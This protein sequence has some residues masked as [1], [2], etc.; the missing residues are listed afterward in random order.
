[1]SK[2]IT[3]TY[4][5]NGQ[6]IDVLFT[7]TAFFNATVAAKAFGKKINDWLR[8]ESTAEYITAL[9]ASHQCYVAGNPVSEQNQLVR[10]VHGGDPA[11]Q[12]TW[13]HAKLAVPYAR[14]LNAN[15]AVWCDEIIFNLLRGGEPS[16]ASRPSFSADEQ[17]ATKLECTL[18]VANLLAVPVH[19]AQQEAVKEVRKE[20]GIDYTHLLVH[21]AAQ[22]TV[23]PDEVM[24]EPTQLSSALKFPSPIAVN[25]W[26]ASL[27]LQNKLKKGWEPTD[28]G[29]KYCS[30]HAWNAKN[31]SGYNLRWNHVKL[32]SLRENS[33][34]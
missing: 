22:Q 15:F 2:L 34:D 12:G 28:E 29:K 25:K 20:T 18:R 6:S 17:A 24:L 11:N 9:I 1:M 21:A 13:L 27:G 3:K 19:I 10:I 30:I 4:T 26:L 7:E 16:P 8:L 5:H 32:Q 33:N 23:Q 14:W 31:K